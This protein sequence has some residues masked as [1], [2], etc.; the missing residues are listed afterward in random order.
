MLSGSGGWCDWWAWR[1]FI[2]SLVW[3]SLLRSISDT[4]ICWEIWWLTVPIR[5]G[6]LTLRIFGCS[7]GSST[8]LQSWTGLAVTFW[9]GRSRRRWIRPS[10]SRHWTSFLG[11]PSQRSSIQTRGF[12]S[13]V[14][15][16]SGIFKRQGFGLAWMVV[17][18]SMITCS[19]NVFGERL[20]MKKFIFMTIQWSWMPITAWQDIFCF[21]IGR[22]CTPLWE[23]GLPTR[24]ISSNQSL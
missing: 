11:S 12:S 6:V 24:S 14:K 22:G 1:P 20:S 3:A 21:I 23:I 8:W 17:V 19:W 18:G 16:L 4:R 15:S 10:V 2:L 9:P 7:M 5:S 13:P